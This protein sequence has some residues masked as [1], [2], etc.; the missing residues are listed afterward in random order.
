M[1]GEREK[2]SEGFLPDNGGLITVSKASP[3]FPV[4]QSCYFVRCHRQS[5]AFFFPDKRTALFSVWRECWKTHSLGERLFMNTIYWHYDPC[6]L[7]CGL[8]KC[9]RREEKLDFHLWPSLALLFNQANGPIKG[10]GK[11]RGEAEWWVSEYNLW[12]IKR[13]GDINISSCLDRQQVLEWIQ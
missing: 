8:P 12:I 6:A 13:G 9:V 5:A 2:W 3:L 4:G 11:L 10:S 1:W 7:A